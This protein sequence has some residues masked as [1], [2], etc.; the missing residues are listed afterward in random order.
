MDNL[1]VFGLLG[2]LTSLGIMLGMLAPVKEIAYRQKK[3][4]SQSK[5]KYGMRI[6]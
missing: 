5:I 1:V 6:R 4:K 2:G 3:M